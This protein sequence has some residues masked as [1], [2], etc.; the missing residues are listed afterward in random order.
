VV[1]GEADETVP[2]ADVMRWARPQTLPVTVI[3][4]VEHF[5]HGQ[6][7]LLRSLVVRHLLSP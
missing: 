1:H 7:P 2:L 3:P 5:F 4:A 6:L